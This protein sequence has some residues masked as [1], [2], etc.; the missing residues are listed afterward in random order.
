[1]KINVR[2]IFKGTFILLLILTIFTGATSADLYDTEVVQGNKF[3]AT[4]LAFSH[5]DTANN[6]PTSSL[7]NITGI[8]PGGFKVE[9]TRIQ[10]DGK[11]SFKYRVKTVKTAGDDNFCGSLKLTV[12]KN[13]EIKYNDWLPNFVMDSN[14]GENKIDDWIFYITLPDNSAGLINKTCDFNFVFR[15]WRNEPEETKGFFDQEILTNHLT[16]GS[17]LPG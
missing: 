3:S 15:T 4:T 16:S 14:M 2:V 11:M 17:W 9:G 12:L 13:W 8:I 1:V 7:F 6:S 5:R 10:K